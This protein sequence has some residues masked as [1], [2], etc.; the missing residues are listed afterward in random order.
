MYNQM[1]YILE[2]FPLTL[3]NGRFFGSS[4]GC[5]PRTSFVLIY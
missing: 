2:P 5:V 4:R 1:L 3:F